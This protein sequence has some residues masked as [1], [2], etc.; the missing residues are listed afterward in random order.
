MPTETPAPLAIPEEAFAALH[1][2]G[3][4]PMRAYVQAIAAPVVAAELRR[5]TTLR[6]FREVQDLLV[7]RANEL[8]PS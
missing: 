5:L 3:D 2:A 4:E 1:E 6:A 7:A 8:D